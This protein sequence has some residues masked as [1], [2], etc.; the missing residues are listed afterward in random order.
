MSLYE[1]VGLRSR[2]RQRRET[3]EDRVT[4]SDKWPMLAKNIQVDWCDFRQSMKDFIDV[5]DVQ[6]LLRFSLPAAKHNVINFLGT[7][8][9]P[10]Q[11]SALGDALNDLKEINRGGNQH[12]TCVCL[13]I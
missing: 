6:P 11:D 3:K 8:S 9:R 13:L 1:Y 4:M 7:D 5:L 12:F 2:E 10:L